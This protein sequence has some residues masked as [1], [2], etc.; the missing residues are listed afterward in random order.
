MTSIQRRKIQALPSQAYSP[1]SKR[2][3]THFTGRQ[4]TVTDARS[5]IREKEWSVT[6]PPGEQGI[7]GR[8]ERR[9][10]D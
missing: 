4:F 9:A 2:A 10:E 7:L 3:K 5:G 1:C 6:V 8:T